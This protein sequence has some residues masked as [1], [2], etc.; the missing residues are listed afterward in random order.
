MDDYFKKKLQAENA[1]M[2][3]IKANQRAHELLSKS[4]TRVPDFSFPTISS[5]EFRMPDIHIPSPEERNAY[6]S[7]SVLMKSIAEEALLWKQRLPELY[8]T[9][10]LAILYGGTQVNVQNLSQVSF[11]GI[12]I[13]G[14][15][16]GAPCSLFAHQSTV[17]LLCY[18]EKLD[19]K[20]QR[21]PIGFVWGS[22]R[23]EV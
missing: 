1:A 19:D 17:Q 10:I 7:A 5:P 12:R 6:Q 4:I 20:E 3:H 13:E 8:S 23:V 11:H 2:E 9:A 22:N 21:N 14:T 16:V 15:L 18:A